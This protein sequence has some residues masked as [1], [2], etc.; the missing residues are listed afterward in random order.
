MPGKNLAMAREGTQFSGDGVNL[1]WGLGGPRE[2]SPKPE[3]LSRRLQLRIANGYIVETDDEATVPLP[4]DRHSKVLF[5]DRAREVFDQPPGQVKVRAA[6]RTSDPDPS[7]DKRLRN[8]PV[9][10]EEKPK[11]RPRGALSTRS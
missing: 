8:A 10:Q 2:I 4:E 9:A 11:A 1:S 3:F 6:I 7:I 5:G